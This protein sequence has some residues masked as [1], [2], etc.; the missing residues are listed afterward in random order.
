MRDEDIC[1]CENNPDR[2]GG[3]YTAVDAWYDDEAAAKAK[4]GPIA[5]WNVSEVADLSKL[6]FGKEEFNCDLSR[7][8]VSSVESMLFVFEGATSFNGDLSRWQVGQVV[9]VCKKNFR[10]P[11]FFQPARVF[12]M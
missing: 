4:Y 12:L 5:S 8:N 7:W 2:E 6:F 1:E 11:S 9:L 10:E 3:I